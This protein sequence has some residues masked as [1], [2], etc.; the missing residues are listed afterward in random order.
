MKK[1]M[2]KLMA[3][4]LSAAV[5]VS[6]IPAQ[7]I[8]AAPKVT[9]TD[10][11]E[12]FVTSYGEERTSVINDGWKFYLGTSSSAQNP[13]F[14]DSDWEN[15]DLPHDFSITQEFTTNGEAESGFLL[16]GTGWYRKTFILPESCAGKRVVLNFDGVYSLATVYVNGTRVGENMYGYTPFAFDITD[17]ITCDSAT[18][19]LIAVEAV[20]NV[21]SSRWYSGSGIY[22]DVKLIVTDPVHVALNGT[23]VTTPKLKE[24]DGLDGTVSAAVEVQ[25]DSSDSAQVT[26]RNTVFEKGST[27]EVASAEAQATVEAGTAKTVHA[28]P[29][30]DAPKLW[31]VDTPNLYVLR[32]EIVKDGQ[33]VDTYD[34]EFG[35][36][37]YE[38]AGNEGFKLNGENVK[39]NGVCMHHDQGALGSAAYYDA[40]YRQ[41]QVMKNMGVNTIRATH[42]PYDEDFVNICNEL[43]LMVIEESFDGWAWPKNGNSNDFSAHFM[44]KLAA[45][46]QVIGG[47]SSMTWAEFTLK[48]MIRRD[49]NDA[50]IILWSLGNEIQEGTADGSSWDWGGI[51]Q[52]LISWAK[53]VDDAHPLTSGSNRKNLTDSVSPVMR[54]IVESG[55]VAG[56]NYATVGQLRSFAEVYNNV[57]LASETAS[58]TGSRGIYVSQ[59]NNTNVD[60][61]LHLTSYST[62]TVGWGK[63][64]PNSLW[65][66]LPYDFVAGECVWTGFDYI[67]EPTPYNGVGRGSVSGWGA[68]P[69]SSYFGIVDTAGFPKDSYYLYR[70]QWNQK[71][72][73]LHLVTAWDSGNM[74]QTGGKTPVWVY[75]NAAKV[76]LYRDDVLVGTATRTVNTTDAGHQYYTYTTQ[77]NDS[78]CTTTSGSGSAS[79]YSVFN[80]AFADGTLSAKA[81]DESGKEIT[82]TCEGKKEVTTPGAP[83]NL[84]VEKNKEEILADGSSLAYIS[85]DVTDA[86]GNFDTK[87]TN[88]IKFTLEGNG[89]I[90]GVDNGDQATLDKFQQKTVLESATSAHIQAFSGKALVIVKSTT[91]AG[92]FTVNVSAEGLE[93]DSVTVSTAQA[94]GQAANGIA[95]YRLSRHCYVPAGTADL[96]LPAKT[97]VT[98]K[99]GSTAELPIQWE[100]YDKANL[101]K[102]GSFKINGSIKVGTDQ[103]A[104]YITAH[105]YSPIASVQ[106]Y[107]GITSPKMVPTLP[108]SVMTYLDDGSAFEEFPVTWDMSGI[109][110]DSF[111]SVGMLVTINGTVSALGGTYPVTAVIRVAEPIEGEKNNIAPTASEITSTA[112]G[113]TLL[114]IKNGVKYATKDDTSERWSN[115]PQRNEEGPSSITMKWDTAHVVDQINLYY[116]LEAGTASS[117]APTSI[118]FEYSLNGT[119]FSPVA[120]EEPVEL[121]TEAGVAEN[122]YSFQLKETVVPIAVRIVLGHD[123]GKFIGLTEVEVIE[124][125]ISYEENT[126]AD[127]KGVTVSGVSV[128]F[129]SSKTEYVVDAPSLDNIVV[130]N[131]VNAS[132]TIVKIGEATAKIIAKSEDGKTTKTYTI[133]LKTSPSEV[134]AEALRKE[135]RS[136]IAAAKAID[137]SIYTKDSYGKLQSVIALIEKEMGTASEARLKELVS[138]LAAAQK[139][140]VKATVSPNPAIK[141]GD[142]YKAKTVEGKVLD[143]N[144]KTVAITKISKTGKKA[145]KIT[146]PTTVK[147]NGVTCQVVQI[148]ANAFKGCSKL[149]SVVIGKNVKLIQKNAFYGCSKLSKVTFQGTA[150]KTIKSGAF[151][152]T[153]AKMTVKVPKTL[154]KNKKAL[155]AF[156]K[157]LTKAGM[158]KK[159]V[160][161]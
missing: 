49:R 133:T 147:V 94:P 161:K 158:N 83:A 33:V 150:V 125:P 3:V 73:T 142:S 132:V 67:G 76:E 137:A 82:K 45:T 68:Y 122:G 38:F 1:R 5:C 84:V 145:S 23:Y 126:S 2:K 113:D 20:N 85:V 79:L 35:F 55:G 13:G 81:Y 43:G 25:N 149:K 152:K 131:D 106:N 14:N 101:K 29:A 36:K 62:S 66:T 44:E 110:A 51:A 93:G 72:N 10:E 127:L 11:Q 107:T 26:V 153:A 57:V 54:K 96:Q 9:F 154:K 117:Q 40:M 21:P 58:A 61:K 134:R 108:G 77:S 16:G 103:M 37:W 56:Y 123:V 121:P 7:G 42:N 95:S 130:A 89:E 65:D 22:R 100:A 53:E 129:D 102:N 59:A 69:N 114:S 157:K 118:A 32:T 74:M 71:A 80:V 116:Y 143:A 141:K 41:M 31:S 64:A 86:A 144:A 119:D 75:S 4:V 47:D 99:D 112:T 148:G 98:Y 12:V 109:T 39:I 139:G 52:N 160:I 17:Y 97:K 88:D 91:E 146:I 155:K 92:S 34:T 27:E 87:A 24:S 90:M 50:S 8:Q 128:K 6:M 138:Q 19:N 115:W 120:Y 78:A 30:V 46:N 104:L 28:D 151:K 159:A 111:A 135:L 63:T 124:T 60:G 156:Q 136:Q 15:I 18:E 70:S 140:L 105:V 48:S